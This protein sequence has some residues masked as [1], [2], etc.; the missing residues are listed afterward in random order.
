MPSYSCYLYREPRRNNS[1]EFSTFED[2][3]LCKYMY[4]YIYKHS[5]IFQM[6]ILSMIDGFSN[7]IFRFYAQ[8]FTINTDDQLRY[9]LCLIFA[10]P[11]F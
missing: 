8:F 2:L 1:I 11:V 9:S 4:M 10:H 3:Q 5:T 7:Y 6:T